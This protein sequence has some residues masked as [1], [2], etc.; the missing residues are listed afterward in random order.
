[1]ARLTA[2]SSV[3]V[4][5][6]LLVPFEAEGQEW[7]PPSRDMPQMPQVSELTADWLAQRAEWFSSAAAAAGSAGDLRVAGEARRGT[8]TAQV[9]RASSGP[10][11]VVVWQDR[12]GDGRVDLIEVFRSGAVMVQVIDADY[13]GAANVLRSYDASGSL[14]KED[15]L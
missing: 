10:V 9:V 3:S 13:D 6:A 11:P 12:N 2:L 14:Q 15:R 8:G 4:L 5:V 1:M 7:R